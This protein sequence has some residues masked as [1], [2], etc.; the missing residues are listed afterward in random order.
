MDWTCYQ[1]KSIIERKFIDNLLEKYSCNQLHSCLKDI[2]Q[3]SYQNIDKNDMQRIQRALEV[4][5]CTGNP[6][7]SF[8]DNKIKLSDEYDVLTL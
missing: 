2:D 1:K 8:F 7:T 3:L 6:I 4:Y 5:I